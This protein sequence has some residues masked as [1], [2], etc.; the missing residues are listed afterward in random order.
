VE[1][2][3]ALKKKKKKRKRKKKNNLKMPSPGILT[4]GLSARLKSFYLSHRHGE[5]G[6]TGF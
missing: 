6:S 3:L 5:P 2:V 1:W 4:N